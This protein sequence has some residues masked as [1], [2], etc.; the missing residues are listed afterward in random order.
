MDE[1]AQA[2]TAPVIAP[3]TRLDVRPVLARGE[4]PFALI[5]QALEEMPTG[6]VLALE[7]PFDPAPLHRVMGGKGYAHATTEIADGY[8]MTEYWEPGAGGV[9]TGT[10]ITL[11]V[12]GL[13][14]PRPMELTLDALDELPNRGV[15]VQLNDRVP[16]FLLPHLEECGFEYAIASDDRGTVVTIW[17]AAA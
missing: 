13:E 17:R 11:D 7:T 16:Q 5:M 4:E 8:F 15:L 3:R 9:P 12:R 10:A 1:H 2:A 6:N 14:P